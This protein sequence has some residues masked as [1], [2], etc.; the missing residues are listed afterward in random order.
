MTKY[1]ANTECTFLED[2]LEV[3]QA[4]VDNM[5]LLEISFKEESSE[6]TRWEPAYYTLDVYSIEIE[7]IKDYTAEQIELI[8]K[9]IIDNEEK[10]IKEFECEMTDPNNYDW[11]GPF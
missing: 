7:N 10:I 1:T 9:I 2:L 6:E 11:H 5:P 4:I 3:D 8:N